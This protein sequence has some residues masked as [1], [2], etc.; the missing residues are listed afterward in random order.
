[1][2]YLLAFVLISTAHATNLLLGGSVPASGFIPQ[3]GYT[4]TGTPT[5][6][7]T[8]TITSSAG[9]FVDGSDNA[10]HTKPFAVAPLLWVPMTSN[11]YGSSLGRISGSSTWSSIA[12]MSWRSGCGPTGTPGCMSGSANPGDGASGGPGVDLN[13][14]AGFDLE[15]WSGWSSQNGGNGYYMNDLGQQLY[16]WRQED[17]VGFGYLS[18]TAAD[19]YN[20]LGNYNVKNFREFSVDPTTHAEG[21]PDLMYGTAFLGWDMASCTNSTVCSDLGITLNSPVQYINS[22]TQGAPDD[23]T[24]A[25]IQGEFDG[26]TNGSGCYNVYC[27]VEFMIATNSNAS[28]S[29]YPPSTQMWYSEVG[30]NGNQPIIS[31]PY[32]NYQNETTGVAWMLVDSGSLKS[33]GLGTIDRV[34]PVQEVVD[35]TS[36]CPSCTDMPSGAYPEYG[37]I[38]ADDSWCHAVIQDSSTYTGA[39][40]REIQIPVSIWN[41][42]EVEIDLRKGQFSGLSGKYL[43]IIPCDASSTTYGGGAIYI[44]QFQ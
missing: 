35:G 27:T 33:D 14:S 1:M 8:I 11:D 42:T 10:T 18:H 23:S 9:G 16:I 41:D 29:S 22:T 15:E 21:Q 2:R 38:Y 30:Q 34:Y 6:G 3:S 5:D 24:S 4:V 7:G 28:A 25:T 43:F 12:L 20:G 37:P 36:N 26:M 19:S 13:Y 44:G 39:T 32:K 40:Q 17:H 31:Y